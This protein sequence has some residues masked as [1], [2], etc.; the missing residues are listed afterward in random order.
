MQQAAGSVE[1]IAEC[2]LHPVSALVDSGASH[3]FVDETVVA[4]CGLE[5]KAAAA[6]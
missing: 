4:N 2:D 1:T 3:C 5:S 6:M